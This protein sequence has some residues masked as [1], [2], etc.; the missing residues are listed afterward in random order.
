MVQSR[1]RRVSRMLV[2]QLDALVHL[3]K[4]NLDIHASAGLVRLDR[5]PVQATVF[6]GSEERVKHLCVVAQR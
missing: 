3:L 1:V 5:G 4:P 6:T 2:V